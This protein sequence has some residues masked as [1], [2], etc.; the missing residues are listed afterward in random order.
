MQLTFPLAY[1]GH[2]KLVVGDRC[3]SWMMNCAEVNGTRDLCCYDAVVGF[4]YEHEGGSA[5]RGVKTML[6]LYGR[7]RARAVDLS[8][9]VRC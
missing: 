1:L 5:D 8:S 7:H 9:A 4:T 3:G 6:A 2:W